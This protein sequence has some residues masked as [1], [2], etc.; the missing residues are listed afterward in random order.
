MKPHTLL[1]AGALA[2]V[3]TAA[4]AA[5]AATVTVPYGAWLVALLSGVETAAVGVAGWL[6]ATL[7]PPWVKMIVTRA[8]IANAVDYAFGAVEGAVL[9]QKLDLKTTNYMLA[10]AEK[11]LIA[12][13]PTVGGWLATT[14][15]P[16]ILAELSKRGVVPADATA[17]NTGTVVPAQ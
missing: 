3:S 4:F 12:Q 10:E 1:V 15:R 16:A 11:Y 5:D 17:I 9:D 8:M 2:L 14:V 6:V 13:A 7:A